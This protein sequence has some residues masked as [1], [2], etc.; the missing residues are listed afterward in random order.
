V[1]IVSLLASAT[2]I[3]CTLHRAF[4]L[5][6]SQGYA[7][8][9]GTWHSLDRYPLHPPDA[10]WVIITDHETQDDLVTADA[11]K[12][13]MRLTQEVDYEDRFGVRFVLTRDR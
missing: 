9:R 4:L 1:K 2:E 10:R 8:A 11:S 5:D 6:G 7:L 12:H 3:V 13:E